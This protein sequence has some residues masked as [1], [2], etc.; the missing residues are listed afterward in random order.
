MPLGSWLFLE[1]FGERS[2]GRNVRR[3]FFGVFCG[4]FSGVGVFD[5]MFR[6]LDDMA[7]HHTANGFG[8]FCR[9]DFFC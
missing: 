3:F 1:L 4:G 7:E 6:E 5:D 8:T 2:L 9:R